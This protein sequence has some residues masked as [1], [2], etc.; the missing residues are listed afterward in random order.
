[1]TQEGPYDLSFIPEA[2]KT[3][4]ALAA[5]AEAAYYRG[6]QVGG[7]EIL[8]RAATDTKVALRRFYEHGF[9]GQLREEQRRRVDRWDLQLRK[10]EDLFALLGYEPA[11]EAL[12]LIGISDERFEQAVGLSEH[13]NVEHIE[14][15]QRMIGWLYG[16]LDEM[17][18][19]LLDDMRTDKFVY[20]VKVEVRKETISL[21]GGSW[22]VLAKGL[23][24]AVMLPVANLAVH[25]LQPNVIE[26][27][28]GLQ[29]PAHMIPSV[30]MVLLSSVQADLASSLASFN[31]FLAQFQPAPTPR[32]PRA[33]AQPNQTIATD[34]AY[35]PLAHT[36]KRR[37]RRPSRGTKDSPSEGFDVTES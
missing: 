28:K 8:L 6:D 31:A 2:M 26:L 37:Q 29:D 12:T 22:R 36:P 9:W 23:V 10:L 25:S 11:S 24:I 15:A 18:K 1:V 33:R 13:D 7:D 30:P 3:C 5:E 20:D 17:I 4:Q 32:K 34:G 35:N 27:V 19:K 14:Q 21:I 16:A